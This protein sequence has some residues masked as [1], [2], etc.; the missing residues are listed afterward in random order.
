MRPLTIVLLIFLLTQFSSCFDQPELVESQELIVYPNPSQGLVAVSFRNLDAEG[1]LQVVDPKGKIVLD[2]L[3][4]GREDI[5]YDF[6]LSDQIDGKFSILFKVG[7]N[8][9]ERSF[10]KISK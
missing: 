1:D 4:R 3:M 7:P 8:V 9:Y 10:I 6:D 2:N 5:T